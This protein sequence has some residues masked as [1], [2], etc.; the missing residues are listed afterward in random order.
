M[1]PFYEGILDTGACPWHPLHSPVQH[2]GPPGAPG[3]GWSQL[4]VPIFQTFFL[5]KVPAALC[6]Q[7]H[8]SSSNFCSMQFPSN[9]PL[10]GALFH[11]QRSIF[12]IF[13]LIKHSP[14]CSAYSIGSHFLMQSWSLTPLVSK[15]YVFQTLLLSF[16]LCSVQFCAPI[17]CALSSRFQSSTLFPWLCQP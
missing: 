2:H 17:H 12:F 14:P 3:G 9:H 4:R 5:E 10:T 7:P 16:H 1:L 15:L 11:L 13:Y 8:C 6:P